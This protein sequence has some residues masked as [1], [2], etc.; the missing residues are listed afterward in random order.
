MHIKMQKMAVTFKYRHLGM[1]WEGGEE[2]EQERLEDDL[3]H[4]LNSEFHLGFL[5]PRLLSFILLYWHLLF[6]LPSRCS[7]WPELG[8]WASTFLLYF[9]RRHFISLQGFK[10]FL[11]IGDSQAQ[12]ST[13]DFPLSS[14]LICETVYLVTI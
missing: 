14:K 5:S 9:P 11:Y 3:N 1:E 8:S 10:F 6:Y 13:P 12:I 4:L 7:T 2:S